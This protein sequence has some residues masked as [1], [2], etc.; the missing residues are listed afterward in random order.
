MYSRISL[1]DLPDDLVWTISQYLESCSIDK[2][3][4]KLACHFTRRIVLRD[5]V[6]ANLVSVSK[7]FRQSLATI[8]DDLPFVESSLIWRNL[9]HTCLACG[10]DENAKW[11]VVREQCEFEARK[12]A[13][14]CNRFDMLMWLVEESWRTNSQSRLLTPK[15]GYM[16]VRTAIQ[17]G[18]LE[19]LK[20]LIR[21]RHMLVSQ[22]PQSFIELAA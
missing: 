17:N 19:M 14:Q 5:L 2:L 15:Y 6:T 12:A 13:S 8:M 20:W 22:V 9:I 11:I 1:L 21:T 18:N 7:P 10:H 4:F 3:M 16:I